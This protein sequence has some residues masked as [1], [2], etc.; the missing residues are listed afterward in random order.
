LRRELA[1]E[2]QHLNDHGFVVVKKTRERAA[3]YNLAAELLLDFSN[4]GS[5]GRFAGFDF[6]AGEFPF[7]REVFVWW[8]LR[9]KQV[10]IAFDQGANDGN[11]NGRWHRRLLNKAAS[12]CATFLRLRG[13]RDMNTVVKVLLVFVVLLVAIKL[14][15]IIF[16][17]ALV[18]LL[19]ATFLGAIGLSVL[20]V[21]AAIVLTLAV[22]LSPIWVPVLVIVGLV[23]LF[24]KTNRPSQS[25]PLT[26]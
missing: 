26:A 14:S 4:D 21:F 22:A 8:A 7:E 25:P 11:R 9:Q 24:K 5:G 23:S 13:F 18:G 12:D 15:P 2:R 1:D 20:A 17:L 10:S 6:A 16:M 19:A 3:N